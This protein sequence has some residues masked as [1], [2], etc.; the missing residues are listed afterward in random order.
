MAARLFRLF[1]RVRNQTNIPSSE[2]NYRVTRTAR[3][4]TCNY[5]VSIGLISA[6]TVWVDR[7]AAWGAV[8]DNK[9]GGSALLL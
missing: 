4:Q 2:C 7:F 3:N 6:S 5:L 8:Q 1:C 9:A